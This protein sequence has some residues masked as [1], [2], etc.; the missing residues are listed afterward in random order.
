MQTCAGGKAGVFART[1]RHQARRWP[2]AAGTGPDDG[3]P[4]A[5]ARAGI[6]ARHKTAGQGGRTGR[7]HR[8][9]I[10]YNAGCAVKARRDP[11]RACIA[12]AQGLPDPVAADDRPGTGAVPVKP[13]AARSSLRRAPLARACCISWS[14]WPVRRLGLVF[15][16]PAR[17]AV[18]RLARARRRHRVCARAAA[19]ACAGHAPHRRQSCTPP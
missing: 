3:K 7:R 9:A 16:F 5:A 6:P 4:R 1:R 19:M 12:V 2:D 18:S 8:G 15:T 14:G 17:R 13:A 10:V 11:N